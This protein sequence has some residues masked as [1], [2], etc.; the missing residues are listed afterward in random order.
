MTST[1]FTGA[2]RYSS[3]FTAV[4]ERSVGIASL[5]LTQMQQGRMRSGDEVSALRSIESRVVALQATIKAIEDSVGA[6]AWQATSS[7]ASGVRASSAEGVSAGSYTAN[8]TSLGSYSTAVG[9]T[10]VA[11]PSAGNFVGAATTKLTLRITN[12]DNAAA[13]TDTT[14]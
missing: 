10:S 14:I 1:L 8:V 7:D 9:K 13:E 3:D 6:S 5:S 2:S 12:H 11:D 4:I